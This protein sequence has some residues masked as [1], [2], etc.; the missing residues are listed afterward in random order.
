[1]EVTRR[2]VTEQERIKF[3]KT[4]LK[5]NLGKEPEE[6]MVAV[7]YDFYLIFKEMDPKA[8]KEIGE[9]LKEE[10]RKRLLNK[11]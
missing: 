7:T 8:R 6:W 4:Q 1:M 3:I 5:Q 10:K 9:W 2:P 11:K